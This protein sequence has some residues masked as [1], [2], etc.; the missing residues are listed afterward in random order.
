MDCAGSDTPRTKAVGTCLGRSRG[1]ATGAGHKVWPFRFSFTFQ[2]ELQDTSKINT[3]VH[4][5]YITYVIKHLCYIESFASSPPWV[6]PSMPP[7]GKR[8]IL[9]RAE[10]ESL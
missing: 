6:S 1:A 9:K 5:M 3:Q 10:I 8:V 2:E 4:I 7:S